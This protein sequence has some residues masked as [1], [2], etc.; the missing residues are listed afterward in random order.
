M[1]DAFPVV[2]GSDIDFPITL[3]DPRTGNPFLLDD[4]YT[5]TAKVWRGDDQEVL[6]SPLLLL[7]R[8]VGNTD[9][10]SS[11]IVRVTKAM[12]SGL[13]P[14]DYSMQGWADKDGIHQALFGPSGVILR[15][16][17]S[18]GTATA[19]LTWITYDHLLGFDP[20]V[21]MLLGT[22]SNQYGFAEQRADATDK[23]IDMMMN[24]ALLRPGYTKRRTS[25]WNPIHGY[26]VQDFA[27]PPPTR[28]L[29]LTRLRNNR[30][31]VDVVAREIIARIALDL[32]MGSE[33]TQDDRQNPYRTFLLASNAR[34]KEAF[35]GWRASMDMNE[36]GTDDMIL[37]VDVTY[38]GA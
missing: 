12:N 26:E 25:T 28:D 19:R 20:G 38:L 8:P 27:T 10:T 17:K 23:F 6:F 30:L 37:D 21:D 34:V 5:L 16:T 35:D 22:K 15:I 18:P 29:I 11:M 4:T 32:I 24:R 2:R 7:D 13:T 3:F 31:T 36:D 14:G 33:K 1:A 9:P